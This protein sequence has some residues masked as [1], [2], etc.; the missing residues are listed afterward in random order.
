MLTEE[1]K[2]M[3]DLESK[4]W[5]HVGKIF[6][7]KTLIEKYFDA[8]KKNLKI[9]EI[10][11]GTGEVSNFLSHY[12]EVTSLDMS[13][14][15]EAFSK[16]KGVSN[17]ILADINE[18]DTSMFKDKFDLVLALDVLEHIQ[19]DVKTMEIINGL[20]A[21]DGHFFIN[22]PAHKF[23]WSE[24]DEALHHKRRYHITEIKQKLLDTNY[25]IVKRSFFVSFAFPVIA[26][27]RLW[28]NIFKRTT[29]PKTSYVMLP[30]SLN[31]FMIKVLEFEA[32]LLKSMN[33]F[34]G[35]T[36]VVV[37]KKKR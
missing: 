9:L 35:T 32:G 31:N 33:L 25:R 2:K 15:A 30:D 22:V 13:P 26:I 1:Y 18:V 21:D 28:G 37:A 11:S 24:H 27:F 8:D 20:L 5:W 7:L 36:I 29:Y 19:D 34:L 6:L 10:G 4:Y 17:F 23:L 14:E 12:G 3:S 16:E